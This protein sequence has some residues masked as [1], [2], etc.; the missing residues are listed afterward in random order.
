MRKLPFLVTAAAALCVSAHAYDV[1]WQQ[2]HDS[3]EAYLNTCVSKS[4]VDSMASKLRSRVNQ[5]ISD[6]SDLSEDIAMRNIML[7]WAAGATKSIAHKEVP[8]VKQA[9]Y[10]FLIFH[11]KGFDVPRQIRDLLTAG[12]VKEMIEYLDDAVA[13]QKK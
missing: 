9:C 7:D 6:N 2:L 12:N 8:A 13:K 1:P 4:E 10:Y 3:A 11:E 5:K